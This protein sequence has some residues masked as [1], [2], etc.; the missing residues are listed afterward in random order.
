MTLAFMHFINR[1]YI[2]AMVMMMMMRTSL[3]F[4]QLHTYIDAYSVYAIQSYY[5]INNV[6]HN[7]SAFTT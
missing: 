2:F 5:Y 1:L 3:A 7:T 6:R 4:L